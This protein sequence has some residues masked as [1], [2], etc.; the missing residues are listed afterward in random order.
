[1]R[2]EHEA[3][4]V[5][6]TAAAI[7][8]AYNT[9]SELL[10]PSI[11]ML[12]GKTPTLAPNQSPNPRPHRINC[13]DQVTRLKMDNGRFKRKVNVLKKQLAELCE[14]LNTMKDQRVVETVKWFNVKEGY[15]FIN[16]NDIRKGIFVHRTAIT[17]NNPHKIKQSV[18]VPLPLAICRRSGAACLRVI[19]TH[20]TSTLP[21]PAISQN[22]IS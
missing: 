7:K 20:F 12:A 2:R 13:I 5:W 18:R 19:A 15:G 9:S 11:H 6:S 4:A 10:R 3:R 17:R 22:T 14:E 16:R 1:M 21:S 8:D